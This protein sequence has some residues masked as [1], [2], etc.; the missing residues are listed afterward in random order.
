MI[1]VALGLLSTAR[2]N[3]QLLA[4][5]RSSDCAEVTAV[6]SRH[7]GRAEAYAA[8]QGIPRA[9]GSYEDLLADPDV[10]AVY[11]SLPNSLHIQWTVRALEAGKH[12]LCE[13]PLSGSSAEVEVAFGAAER[14]ERQLAEAF[15]YRHHGQTRRLVEL[16]RSRAI[17]RLSFIRATLTFSL[18]CAGDPRMKRDLEGGALMDVGCYCVSGAR[19]LAGEPERVYGERVLGDD[20]VDLR[21]AGM[22]RFPDDVVAQFD[23]AMDQPRRDALEVVGTEGMLVLTDPWHC[24]ARAFTLHRDYVVEEISFYRD[25]PYRLELEDFCQAIRG[26]AEPGS[27]RQEAVAQARAI[28]ALLQSAQAGQPIDV[29]L[30]TRLSSD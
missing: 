24:R 7:K 30:P 2:I 11:V 27:G 28:E 10:E 14:A 19:L 26:A 6:A 18:D 25:N 3:A 22:L 1:P 13:K 15:M 12:V 16:V 8:A 29:P 21:F 5:A 20:G 4:A 23:C 17:G 9:Y